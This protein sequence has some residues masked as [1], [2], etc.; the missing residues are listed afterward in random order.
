MKNLHSGLI[1]LCLLFFFSCQKEETL[2][3]EDPVITTEITLENIIADD[4]LM[5]K[6]F[7]GI[8]D[9]DI[10]VSADKKETIDRIKLAM[11]K[12]HKTTPFVEGYI[13]EVGFP[14][15]GQAKLHQ[16]GS[17]N[18]VY[19]LPFAKKTSTF[20]TAIL[21]VASINEK[22]VYELALR[23]DVKEYMVAYNTD[24]QTFYWE[25]LL[26]F[27]AGFNAYDE[28]IFGFSDSFILEWLNQNQDTYLVDAAD[29][30]ECSVG[31]LKYCQN[32]YAL[33]ERGDERSSSCGPSQIEVA[34]VIVVCES[35]TGGGG[36][37]SVPIIGDD[38]NRGG[39]GSPSDG[40]SSPGDSPTFEDLLCNIDASI[41]FFQTYNI[42]P[43]A[44]LRDALGNIAGCEGMSQGAF[45]RE[46]IISILEE[47]DIDFDSEVINHLLLTNNQ[48]LSDLTTFLEN[49]DYTIVKIFIIDGYIMG[50]DEEG[51]L[52]IIN[53]DKLDI[54][55][56]SAQQMFD[57][58]AEVIHCTRLDFCEEGQYRP[59]DWR[60]YF[61]DLTDHTWFHYPYINT[62]GEIIQYEGCEAGI[63][64]TTVWG[65]FLMNTSP[66]FRGTVT[67]DGVVEE[68][69]R[70]DSFDEG[71]NKS[72][73]TINMPLSCS[74]GFLNQIDFDCE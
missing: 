21:H 62:P 9:H 20:T 71:E 30:R 68:V 32:I 61:N 8:N 49:H 69:L 26:G 73:L 43:T 12:D 36:S 33:D 47:Y 66:A 57:H 1:L 52:R 65:G 58:M 13:R 40:G 19:A 3:Q 44:V 34:I 60:D 72:I 2:I 38:D 48:M 53:L 41:S 54:N 16:Q 56:I 70:W 31:R 27:L 28:N 74:E 50:I 24:S 64:F 17:G 10:P 22:F 46:A 15:W 37:P 4:P 55:N 23:T 67:N 5:D 39:G 63:E 35:P 6:F 59:I 45:N 11:I 14:L 18:F 7:N 42:E 25:N 29:T 51:I